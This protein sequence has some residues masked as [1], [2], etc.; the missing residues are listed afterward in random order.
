MT[1]I[2]SSAQN[3]LRFANRGFGSFPDEIGPHKPNPTQAALEDWF[4]NEWFPQPM[5]Y[6]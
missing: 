3:F 4:H 2:V 5:F 1:I 6:R